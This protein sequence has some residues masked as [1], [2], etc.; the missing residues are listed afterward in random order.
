MQNG[1]EFYLGE[2]TQASS[3]YICICK[4]QMNVYAGPEGRER[5]KLKLQTNLNEL[6]ELWYT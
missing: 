3:V 1:F 6:D 2:V 5:E 4:L